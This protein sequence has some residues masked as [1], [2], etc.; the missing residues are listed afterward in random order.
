MAHLPVGLLGVRDIDRLTSDRLVL[1]EWRQS[2]ADALA[3]MLDDAEVMHDWG[4]VLSR[5]E[6]DK[7]LF[8]YNQAIAEFGF[9]RWLVERRTGEFLGYCGVMPGFPGHPLGE[10]FEIGWRFVR[11]AWGHGYATEAARTAI[12]DVFRR[13]GLTEVLSYT[14][15][16]NNRSRAVMGRLSLVRD[17]SRD[18]VGGIDPQSRWQG[19]VWVAS[20][21]TFERR[22]S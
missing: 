2:D 13:V 17:A 11:N 18:F 14:T 8:R 21:E 16:E 20:R 19:L 15:A 10:H 3:G 7:K 22:S 1:R 4:G 12:D 6:S 5:E 9:G